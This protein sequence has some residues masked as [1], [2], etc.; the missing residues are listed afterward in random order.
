MARLSK[1]TLS[2][3]AEAATP[4]EVLRDSFLEDGFATLRLHVVCRLQ[5]ATGVAVPVLAFLSLRRAQAMARRC[6]TL[7]LEAG[8][9]HR[10]WKVAPE[11][12]PDSDAASGQVQQIQPSPLVSG[13]MTATWPAL[14]TALPGTLYSGS[15]L[16][17]GPVVATWHPASWPEGLL[18][19]DQS[20]RN[21]GPA[22][23]CYDVRDVP[24]LL[25]EV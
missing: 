7:L 8:L 10:A 2:L 22:Y 19:I 14:G 15:A 11:C 5:P 17:S 12:L 25:E 21:A 23:A 24:C 4:R 9:L 3:A 1:Q 6:N 20:L 16:A 13:A 18:D